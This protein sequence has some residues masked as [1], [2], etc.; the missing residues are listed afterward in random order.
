[1]SVIRE[2]TEMGTKA[3]LSCV[4]WSRSLLA[5]LGGEAEVVKPKQ[6]ADIA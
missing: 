3:V 1:M 4:L 6:F 5:T 2:V